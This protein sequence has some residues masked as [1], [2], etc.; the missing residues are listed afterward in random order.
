MLTVKL[1][2]GHEMHIVEAVDVI[3]RNVGKPDPNVI[4][5]TNHPTDSIREVSV[6][7][8][9]G[10]R[11]SFHVSQLGALPGSGIP[12]WDVAYIENAHGATTERVLPGACIPEPMIPRIPLGDVAVGRTVKWGGQEGECRGN[13]VMITHPEN[14]AY[15]VLWVDIGVGEPFPI[16]QQNV[17]VEPAG[18]QST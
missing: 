17:T 8:H 15:P 13:V 1:I 9:A 5:S 10:H 2:R 4:A 12:T 11:E 14:S 7:L 6:L 3:V 16:G 18:G